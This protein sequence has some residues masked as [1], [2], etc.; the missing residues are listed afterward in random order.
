[1]MPPAPRFPASSQTGSAAG[2][3]LIW[4]TA[5]RC[6]LWLALLSTAIGLAWRLT[7]AAPDLALALDGAGL[8]LWFTAWPLAGALAQ[9]RDRQARHG[10]S[11][12]LRWRERVA[13]ALHLWAAGLVL[14]PACAG[15][16]LGFDGAARLMLLETLDPYTIPLPVAWFCLAV[17]FLA[18]P[19]AVALAT[20]LL[21][22]LK[23]ALGAW[24]GL[25]A[26]TALALLA[27]L[28]LLAGA[29]AAL[30][31]WTGLRLT[32]LGLPLALALPHEPPL[33]S[34]PLGL[35]LGQYAADLLRYFTSS[36]QVA[37]RY[38]YLETLLQ[39]A[40]AGPGLALLG[41][42]LGYLALRRVPQPRLVWRWQAP[43]AAGLS[44]LAAGL[45]Q[46][47]LT[48]GWLAQPGLRFP[49][50]LLGVFT[51]GIAMLW[52]AQAL[53][54]MIDPRRPRPGWLDAAWTLLAAAGWLA[55]TMPQL[56]AGQ[57]GLVEAAALAGLAALLALLGQALLAQLAGGGG[58]LALALGLTLTVPV[59]PGGSLCYSLLGWLS[60]AWTAPSPPVGVFAAT[61]ALI[62][63]TLAL[64]SWPQRQRRAMP[65]PPGIG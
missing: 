29:D 42:C 60:S 33:R 30:L 39:R 10:G 25:Y 20:V 16:L 64:W 32:P 1:M 46:G 15:L 55:L 19:P 52:L 63:L 28:P 54:Y 56:A 4:Q 43:W 41:A 3:G 31:N 47:A 17:L 13:T 51:A 18:G 7:G 62:L 11:P 21:L 14:A 36:T 22:W 37:G 61:A 58:W 57:A 12:L 38:V 8:A 6:A 34:Y 27:H 40:V 35:G 59:G 49:A 53:G 2:L 50:P 26:W 48:A 44:L 24:G 5:L 65:S 23:R 9:A 45:G